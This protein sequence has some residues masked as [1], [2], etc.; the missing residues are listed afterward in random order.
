MSTFVPISLIVSLEMIK[1]ILCYFIEKDAL[2]YSNESDK[3]TSCVSMT[4]HEQLA[5]TKFIFS[6][7]TGTLTSN[8]MEFK[9]CTIGGKLYEETNNNKNETF[10]NQIN[11]NNLNYGNQQAYPT[12]MTMQERLPTQYTENID[13][14]MW[15]YNASP[16]RRDMRGQ[17]Q[18]QNYFEQNENNSENN[19]TNAELI[20][21]FW[22]C[23]AICNEI[24]PTKQKDNTIIFQGPSP[25]EVTLV[26][27]AREVGFVLVER[28]SN[29]VTVD[30]FESRTEII[31]LQKLEFS[32]ERKCMSVIAQLPDGTIKLYIKGADDVM[33]KK[34]A[35]NQDRSIKDLT[36]QHLKKFSSLVK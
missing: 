27:A 5:K 25:D 12:T 3:Y 9:G 2:M 31:T 7:K 29:S 20:R 33:F 1:F 16:I 36:T 23:L 26:D 35:Q 17:N 6:D 14:I 30:I 19:P 4:L 11:Y 21:E 32:S 15:N 18:N 34:L 24:I 13:R 8:I 10:N 22:L 28:K